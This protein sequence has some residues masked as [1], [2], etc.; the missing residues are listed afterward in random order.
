MVV[1]SI[2]DGYCQAS[3]EAEVD[4]AIRTESV[5]CLEATSM[6]PRAIEG[7]KAHVW[8]VTEGL[9]CSKFRPMLHTEHTHESMLKVYQESDGIY[10]RGEFWYLI[11]H[12]KKKDLF[13]RCLCRAMDARNLD[14]V[15]TQQRR[16]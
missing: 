16:T 9:V 12:Q 10:L 13:R 6:Q 14:Q 8:D 4:A 7:W 15:S 5:S 11:T 3:L 1:R 2:D